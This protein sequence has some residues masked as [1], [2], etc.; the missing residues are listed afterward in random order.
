MRTAI[1]DN[2]SAVAIYF[3]WS[4]P[5]ILPAQQCTISA[6]SNNIGTHFSECRVFYTTLLRSP[7][8]KDMRG[9]CMHVEHT[10]GSKGAHSVR[11]MLVAY[12]TGD[13]FMCCPSVTIPTGD[14]NR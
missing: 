10:F 12:P 14:T 8:R 3:V 6:T 11:G 1:A 4:C 5:K 7:R 9:T 2:L 13:V